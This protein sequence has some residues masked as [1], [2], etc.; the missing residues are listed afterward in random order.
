MKRNERI[1]IFFY[2]TGSGKEPVREFFLE[3]SDD[4]KKIIGTDLK[5]VQWR[6]PTGEPLVKNLGH[7]IFELRSTLKNRIARVLFSQHQDK[8]ILLHAFVKKTQKT[9]DKDIKLAIKRLKE[10]Q[11]EKE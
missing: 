8:L 11:N 6:W 9:D 4:E 2:M 5:V 3:L 1:E 10:I 7:S